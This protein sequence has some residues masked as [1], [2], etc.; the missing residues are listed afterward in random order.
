[1][2]CIMELDDLKELWTQS[3]RKLEASVRL[4]SL[5]VQQMNLGKTES[6]VR[7]LSWGAWFEVGVNLLAVALL[8]SFAAGHLREPRFLIPALS[9]G[10]YALALLI[11]RVRELVELANIDYAEPVVAIQKRLEDLRIRRIRTTIWTLL[12]A[13]LMWVPL[14]VVA[15]RG[16]F[17]VD[18]YTV[19]A[20]SW[21]VANL[22]F[23]LAVIPAGMLLARRYGHVFERFSPV[24]SLADTIAGRS[25]AAAL[26]ALDTIRRFEDDPT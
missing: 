7:R 23:G 25:L 19:A 6:Y 26:D 3:N 16:L 18:V 5:L 21:F 13:P 17:G 15:L 2:E 20:P 9:L 22:L 12:F 10:G 4:N 24:R 1:M 8:G 11:V 14:L